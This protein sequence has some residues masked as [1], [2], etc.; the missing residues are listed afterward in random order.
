MHLRRT[1]RLDLPPLPLPSRCDSC[2]ATYAATPAALEGAVSMSVVTCSIHTLQS[3]Q[4]TMSPCMSH[5]R[6]GQTRQR[7]GCGN[8]AGG[9]GHERDRDEHLDGGLL[10]SRRFQ[11]GQLAI[12]QRDRHEVLSGSQPS[13]QLAACRVQEDDGEAAARCELCGEEPA[14]LDLERGACEHSGPVAGELH[15]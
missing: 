11:S 5:G 6:G 8:A 15:S 1:A 3:A 2:S 13:S 7:V 12:E 9:S 4:H 10:R 14:V